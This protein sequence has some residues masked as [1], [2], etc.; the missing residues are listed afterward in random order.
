MVWRTDTVIFI[1]NWLY[2]IESLTNVLGWVRQFRVFNNWVNRIEW[3]GKVK[4]AVQTPWCL[5]KTSSSASILTMPANPKMLVQARPV[6]HYSIFGW[7]QIFGCSQFLW[8]MSVSVWPMQVALL[9]QREAWNVLPTLVHVGGGLHY[10]TFFA[11]GRRCFSC[12]T[13]YM[14]GGQEGL[15]AQALIAPLWEYSYGP[16]YIMMVDTNVF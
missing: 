9:A 13:G 5:T 7:S 15:N 1:S 11:L 12:A 16:A 10:K 8:Q 6:G 4:G 2:V 14:Q 3:V